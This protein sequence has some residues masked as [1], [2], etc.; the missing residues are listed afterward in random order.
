MA[1]LALG[2]RARRCSA[3]RMERVIM[4]MVGLEIPAVGKTEDPA[5]YKLSTPWNFRFLSTTPS[6]AE[7]DIRVVPMWWPLIVHWSFMLSQ[8]S[9]EMILGNLSEDWLNREQF[10]S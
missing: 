5:I 4:V 3:S 9:Q 8:G 6:A 10:L 1:A 2:I 7:A